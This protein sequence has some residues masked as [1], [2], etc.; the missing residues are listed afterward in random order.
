MNRRQEGKQEGKMEIPLVDVAWQHRQVRAEID[1]GIDRLLND[2]TCDGTEFVQQL[3]NN[4][5]SRIGQGVRAISVQ[6][7]TAAEFLVLR[8]LGIGPGDEVLTVPN[9]DL[10]TTAAISHTGATPVLVDIDPKTYTVDPEKIRAAITPH[11]RAII[12][13]HMYGLPAEMDSIQET[14]RQYGLKIV[15]DSAIALGAEYRGAMTGTLGDAGF[16]S[17]APRKVLGGIGS[18]GM[19][20]TRDPDLAY[21]VRMLRGYGLPPEHMERPIGERHKD[22]GLDHHAEGHNLRLDSVQ[23]IVIEA[24]FAHLDEWRA[25]RQQ[26][27]DRYTAGLGSVPEIELPYVPAPMRH[28]WRNYVIK[29]P[30]RDRVRARLLQQ[31]ITVATFYS[32]PVHLQPVYQHLGLGPGSFPVAEA[33]AQSLLCLPMHPGLTEEQTD[34][35]IAAL[36]SALREE[37]RT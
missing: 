32:P 31:G 24:K 19:V 33:V 17:F 8:A 10:A 37:A 34:L 2:P 11:T 5:A 20:T 25:L 15:E 26:V 7:G 23:A 21:R 13:V 35:I 9:S 27:A 6:S 28:A 3:E 22:P 14:A 16:F 36:T 12:P 1:Q 4:F 30:A 29:I 18:G